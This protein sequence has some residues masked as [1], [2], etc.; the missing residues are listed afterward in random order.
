MT[1]QQD[2]Q[3]RLVRAA[4]LGHTGVRGHDGQPVREV[5]LHVA[6]RVGV[7]LRLPEDRR[8][9]ILQMRRRAFD[10]PAGLQPAD[11]GQPPRNPIRQPALAVVR[12]QGIGADGHRHVEPPRGL[13]AEERAGRDGQ[14]RQRPPVQSNV[15]ADHRGIAAVL[16]LPEAVVEEGARA[17]AVLR[18]GV[19]RQP[20]PED[21]R[22]AEYVEEIGGD[23]QALGIARVA[24]VAE[25]EPRRA[26]CQQTGERLLQTGELVD[27]GGT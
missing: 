26:E 5:P 25:V 4:H 14:D 20:A 19:R 13:H 6:G 24:A 18:I 8:R 3:R 7:R 22:D 11:W 27:L 16:A 1:R 12:E 9:N 2:P 17:R 21:G 10:G 15:S 23:E